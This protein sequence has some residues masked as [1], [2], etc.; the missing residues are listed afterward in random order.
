MRSKEIV[1]VNPVLGMRVMVPHQCVKIRSVGRPDDVKYSLV[2]V[3]TAARQ[4][5]EPGVIQGHVYLL[6]TIQIHV[7]KR[8]TGP[9]ARLS[10]F[11]LAV[12]K[13]RTA[14]EPNPHRRHE[15]DN[16]VQAGTAYARCGRML[17]VRLSFWRVDLRAVL[18]VWPHHGG[19]ASG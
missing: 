9:V 5:K 17:K 4:M 7:T 13:L 16:Q 14:C 1:V 3:R 11:L 12:L 15:L 18:K 10:Y 19:A 2:V 6:T 8:W